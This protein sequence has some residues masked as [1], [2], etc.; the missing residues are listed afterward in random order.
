MRNEQRGFRASAGFLNYVCTINY[1]E[2]SLQPLPRCVNNEKLVFALIM[3]SFTP[4]IKVLVRINTLQLA[5]GCTFTGITGSRSRSRFLSNICSSYVTLALWECTICSRIRSSMKSTNSAYRIYSA[6]PSWI[7]PK[8]HFNSTRSQSQRATTLGLVVK[9]SFSLFALEPF[10][11]RTGKPL[12]SARQ[13][14]H[15]QKH[16]SSVHQQAGST[17][18]KRWMTSTTSSWFLPCATSSFSPLYI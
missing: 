9:L 2:A 13:R 10:V 11:A 18:L 12:V 3:R 17:S 6:A 8:A 1:V 16:D 4:A 5:S 7:S 14:H 15:I